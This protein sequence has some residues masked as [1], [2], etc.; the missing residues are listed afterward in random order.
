[1]CS[2]SFPLSL[3][4]VILFSAPKKPCTIALRE[5][6]A[7]NTR[8]VSS[9][10]CC[11]KFNNFLI[12]DLT[13]MPSFVFSSLSLWDVAFKESLTLFTELLLRVLY[14]H[15]LMWKPVRMPLLGSTNGVNFIFFFQVTYDFLIG[16]CNGSWHHSSPGDTKNNSTMD[17]GKGATCY[18]ASFQNTKTKQSYIANHKQNKS[19]F[20]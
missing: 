12:C 5:Y 4:T 18:R 16:H 11:W 19:C 15:S 14:Q 17:S 3:E 6:Q 1:M 10:L 2:C 20:T 13:N 7:A 9:V 8:F